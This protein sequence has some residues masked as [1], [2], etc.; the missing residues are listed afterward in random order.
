MTDQWIGSV[1]CIN[2]GEVLGEYKGCVSQ[3]DFKNQTITLTN[4]QRNGILCSVPKITLSSKDI[5]SLQI[6]DSITANNEIPCKNLESKVEQE[7]INNDNHKKVSTPKRTDSRRRNTERDDECFNEPVSDFI[8]ENE[9]DFEKNLALFDKQAVFEELQ[10]QTKPDVV[11]LADH[12]L[13][14]Q[15]TKYRCDEN[16]IL[17]PERDM[18]REIRVPCIAEKEFF[19]DSN[20]IVPSI[21]RGLRHTIL[22]NAKAAGF[23][24]ERRIELLG[25]S[26]AEMIFQLVGGS[27]RLNP[28]ITH[29]RPTAVILCGPHVQG[30]QGINCARQL[31]NHNVHV[32]LMVMSGHNS[33]FNKELTLTEHT[34]CK[35]VRSP[36]DLPSNVDIIVGALDSVDDESHQSNTS[37]HNEVKQWVSKCRAP[38]LCLDPPPGDT[39]LSPKW[40]LTILLPFAFESG[41]SVYICDVGIP[42][43]VF[44]NSGVKF[45]AIFGSKFVIPLY[46]HNI[47][48]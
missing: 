44:E 39:G 17:G 21:T 23:T 2:C 11:R 24:E 31:A 29:Q 14:G 26:C 19:T 37:L 3:V 35:I 25:R 27:H 4:V 40:I 6:V 20:V 12:N 15:Q 1:V 16:I 18:F 33:T 42:G 48:R 13:R 36:N 32:Y 8:L 43:K 38:V 30:A 9:F 28:L 46:D 45:I 7:K 10:A 41:V 34:S 22:C 47:T 5:T